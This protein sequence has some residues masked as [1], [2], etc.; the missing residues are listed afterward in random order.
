MVTLIENWNRDRQ[1]LSTV[2]KTSFSRGFAAFG[3]LVLNLVIGQLLGPSGVGLFMLGLSIVL[4]LSE[5]ARMGMN[6]AILRFASVA[7][8]EKDSGGLRWIRRQILFVAGGL[9]ILLGTVLYLCSPLLAIRIFNEPDLVDVLKIMAVVLPVYS[10]I[11][12]QA[13]ML[14]ALKRPAAAPFFEPGSASFFTALLLLVSVY[15]GRQPSPE[16]AGWLL[17][18]AC[19]GCLLAGQIVIQHI[20]STISSSTPHIVPISQYYSVLPNFATMALA[21]YLIQWG[22]TL[23]LG[24][25]ADS[26][27]VGLYSV[28]H[29]LAY[30][31]NFILYVF[32]SII[33]PQFATYHRNGDKK[34]LEALATRSTLYM[35]LLA[36]PMLILYMVFPD[37]ILSLFGKGFARAKAY[38]MILAFAQFVNVSSGSVAFLLN[39]TG[40]ERVMRNI[41]LLTGGISLLL[42]FSLTPAMGAWGTTIATAF[43]LMT[44]NLAAALRVNQLLGIKTI[45]GWRWLSRKIKRKR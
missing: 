6:S 36:S 4:G 2:F 34:E 26:E 42:H 19:C 3:T 28:A 15:L 39:M 25:F 11:H 43:T 5:V 30:V 33:A 22:G 13:S 38:L 40:H 10:Y 31:V 7:Y 16:L 32:N 35:T 23:V 9:S 41:V 14:N 29:R 12:L 37:T 45:P 21:I 44:L 17:L 27:D 24:G 1:F 20:S 18:T 8:S